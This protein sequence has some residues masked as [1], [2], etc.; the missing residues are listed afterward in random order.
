[1]SAK[2]Q[3]WAAF[4]A[5]VPYFSACVGPSKLRTRLLA[6]IRRF[7]EPIV[8]RDVLL[9]RSGLSFF[10]EEFDLDLVLMELVRN[11]VICPVV[12]SPF[13]FAVPRSYPKG[14]ALCERS[15]SKPPDASG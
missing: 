6:A 10:A 7:D 13:T 3:E 1:M 2:Q 11:S 9:L 14:A 15:P 8:T 4:L 5:L 12:N